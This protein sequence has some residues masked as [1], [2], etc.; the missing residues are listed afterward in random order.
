MGK[1]NSF[2][3]GQ[4]VQDIESETIYIFV[5]RIRNKVHLVE[6]NSFGEPIELVL[7]EMKRLGTV[8]TIPET[9]K[10]ISI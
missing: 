8:K 5:K 6:L 1:K 9:F 2:K 10:S 3:R 4:L 7:S